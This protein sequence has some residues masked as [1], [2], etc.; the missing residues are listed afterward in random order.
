MSNEEFWQKTRK[1]YKERQKA[2]KATFATK[3]EYLASDFYKQKV[4]RRERAEK[5]Q[6][7]DKNSY[8]WNTPE[9]AIDMSYGGDMAEKV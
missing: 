4:A 1:A 5:W 3:E 8:A 9:V 2:K 6:M 7:I